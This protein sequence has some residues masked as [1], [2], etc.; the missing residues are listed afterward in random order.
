MGFSLVGV[1]RCLGLAGRQASLLDDVDRFCDEALGPSSIYSF[2]HCERDALFPDGD[3][4]DLFDEKGRNS[5][6]CRWWRW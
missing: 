5:V 3:F 2:F 4:E 6:R 1:V